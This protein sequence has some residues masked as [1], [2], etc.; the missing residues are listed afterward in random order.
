MPAK[1]RPIASREASDSRESSGFTDLLGYRLMRLSASVAQLA[2]R[3]ARE[4]T[5]L[6]LPEYRVLVVL[7][8]KGPLGVAGLQQTVMIDKAW[9][10]R[11]LARLVDRKLAVATPDEFDR[12]R[13][14]FSLTAKGRRAARVLIERAGRRQERVLR[15]LDDEDRSSLLELL[16]RVQKNVDD[17]KLSA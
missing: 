7:L 6:G 3:E 9:V 1:N 16:A 10:S 17:M 2:D 14:R 12:R 5:G 8:A 11:T 15:G 13:T 4:A